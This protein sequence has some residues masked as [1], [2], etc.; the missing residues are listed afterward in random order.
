MFE[1]FPKWKYSANAALIVESAE[2][3]LELGEGWRDTPWSA[4]GAS[5]PDHHD[6]EEAVLKPSGSPEKAE[7][8]A[9]AESLGVQ[10]DKR[11]SAAKIAKAIADHQ[12]A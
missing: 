12:P 8:I 9:Q 3:E 1:E 11:W 7:L 10:F 2:E 4:Q 6:D 5:V